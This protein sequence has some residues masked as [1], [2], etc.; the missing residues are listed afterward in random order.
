MI[1]SLRGKITYGGVCDSYYITVI[2]VGGV[3]FEIKTSLVTASALPKIGEEAALL[4][5]LLVREDAL[6][7]YG[8]EKEEEL[9]AFKRLITVSG[10]GAKMALSL[11]SIF[12]PNKLTQA[13]ASGD[14][15]LISKAKGIGPKLAQRIILELSGNPAK[16]AMNEITLTSGSAADQVTAADALLALGYSHNEAVAAVAALPEGLSVEEQV[17]AALQALFRG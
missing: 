14:A 4:T 9:A 10:V 17:K 12:T 11:L 1:R 16:S 6:E 7:L 13:L 5:W 3:G 8:F 2:E 15:K